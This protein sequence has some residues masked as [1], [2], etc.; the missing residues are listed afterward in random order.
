MSE[1]DEVAGTGMFIASEL[2]TKALPLFNDI[3][4]QLN[5][6][7]KA[8]R[9]YA[10]DVV[11]VCAGSAHGQV[12]SSVVQ[13][14]DDCEAAIRWKVMGFIARASTAQLGSA[15]RHFDEV[16]PDSPFLI[17]L[18]WLLSDQAK[19]VA[20]IIQMI[21]SPDAIARR[22]GAIAAA[23]IASRNREPLNAAMLS[24]DTDVRDFASTIAEQLTIEDRWQDRASRRH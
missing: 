2:G 4:N 16:S 22:V 14:L 23:R 19:D 5:H 8:V 10:T 18:R 11:L 21:H 9:G 24:E 7:A 17:A 13:L 15:I 1:D 6:R 3:S 20:S 12:I